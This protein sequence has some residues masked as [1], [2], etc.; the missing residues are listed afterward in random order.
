MDKA[1]GLKKRHLA[2]LAGKASTLVPVRIRGEAARIRGEAQGPQRQAQLALPVLK[3][4]LADWRREFEGKLK[5][6]KDKLR[7][8]EDSLKPLLVWRWYVNVC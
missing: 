7:T 6:L 1:E 8:A 3:Y 5:D 2:E 4:L